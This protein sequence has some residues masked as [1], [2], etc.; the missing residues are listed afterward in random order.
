MNRGAIFGALVLF[1]AACGDHDDAEVAA[2]VA[3]VLPVRGAARIGEASHRGPARLAAGEALAVS[4]GGVAR[5]T[6][7]AGPRLLVDG[8]AELV[9]TEASRLRLAKG[10][11][12]AE[13]FPGDPLALEAGGVELFADDAALSAS[14]SGAG[15]SA[16][17]VRGEVAYRRGEA[18]GVVHAGERLELEDDA[19]SVAPE[20]L[21][22]D[23]TGG[24]ARPGPE[25][26]TASRGVGVLEGRLPDQVGEARWP[27]VVRRLDVSVRVVGDLAITEVDQVFFNPSSETVEGLYRVEV[28]AGAALHRFAVDRDG[29]LVDG[30]IRERETARRSYEA[31]VYAGSR[32][33]PALLE[34]DAPG[35]Y[36]ARIYPIDPGAE[37]RIVVR[38]SE[39]LGRAASEGPRVYRYPMGGGAR[40]A[41]VQE[42]SFR[43]DLSRTEVDHVRAGLGARVEGKVVSLRRS[44]F[45]PR[46]DLF[47]ELFDPE[48]RGAEATAYR[49]D[50][51]PPP[52]D[53]RA[54]A[55]PA[56]EE[57][58]YVYLPLRLPDDLFGE[59]GAGVDLV[60]VADVSAGTDR[61]RLEL[62]RTTVESLVTHLGPEDRVALMVSDLDVRPLATS[63]ER[64]LAEATPER[65]AALLDAL[66]REP[67][68]GATDL[69]RTLTSAAALLDPARPGAVIYIGDGAPT[70][71]ELS[72]GE[73]LARLGQLPRPLRLYAV[74]VGADADLDLMSA[75]AAG[76]GLA[77]R[78]EDRRE[79]ASAA[80]D[81]LAHARRPSAERVEVSLGT[82]VDRVY[83]RE[84][85]SVVAGAPLEIIGRAR[86][87]LPATIEVKGLVRGEPFER[88]IPLTTVAAEDEGDLRLRWAG[89]R[90]AQLIRDGAER[91]EVADLGT[92]YGVITPY[93]SF[94]VPSAAE[95][96]SM[97]DGAAP[98]LDGARFA[99]RSE[100]AREAWWLAPALPVLGLLGCSSAPEEEAPVSSS[101]APMEAARAPMADEA[102]ANGGA[103]L[104]APTVVAAP[105]AQAAMPPG[106]AEA[107]D[108]RAE[109]RPV[110]VA[111]RDEAQAAAP[112]PP[113]S[114]SPS[115]AAQA[116]NNDP[117]AGLDDFGGMGEGGGGTL[118][119]GSGSGAGSGYGRGAPAQEERGRLNRRSAPSHRAPAPTSRITITTTIQVDH[120]AKRC[121][122]ASFL[123]LEAREALWRERLERGY[124]AYE[125]LGVY[126]RALGQCELPS[127]RA[128]RAFLDLVLRRAGAV[129]PMLDFYALLARASD[130]TYLRRAI[131]RE[132]R[133]TEDLRAARAAFG[134]ERVDFELIE[135]T[136]AGANGE[137]AKLAAMRALV[138]RY[139]NDLDL[140]LRLLEMLE[141]AGRPSDAKR[142][143][144]RL[145]DHPL[146]DAGVRT[147]IGE[148]YLRMDDELE[149]RR[150]FSE[151]VEFAPSDELARRR[152][153]DLYRAHGWYE[154]AY[155]QYQTLASIRPDDPAVFLL[156]AQAAA[157]AGRIDEALR[158]EQRLAE[159]AQPGEATGPAR[160][161]ILWSSVRLAELRKDAR[162]KEDAE[163]LRAY[164]GRMRRG[165]VLREA[166]ALRASLT[167]SHPDANLSLWASHPGLSLTRPT[168]IAPEFGIEAFDL[169]EQEPGVYHVEVR[170][171]E[172]DGLTGV[173][174]KLTVVWREGRDDERVEVIPLR[175][176][177]S[178][179][180]YAWAI[181]GDALREDAPSAAAAEGGR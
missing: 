24:L 175:F 62:G 65:L 158:L 17:V 25:L 124:S 22:R 81:V 86:G 58:D 94:Y 61:S 33:D 177:A 19:L 146:A 135:H 168:D 71:G 16:Y 128:R 67:A 47:L 131:L 8:G 156:L 9:L 166:G 49:A 44:D 125:W 147:A 106:E 133:S 30:Y 76:S 20:S 12:F 46:S 149:A 104:P 41:E 72:S 174:A 155:R 97:G 89:A 163:R 114:P 73:L 45:R 140:S 38:Y 93:T 2:S 165:G 150:A 160:T 145:R 4:E 40:A 120:V 21:F 35:K 143:A 55:A 11:I 119:H 117:L 18:R 129:R 164:L 159:T 176:D 83:P 107:A 77:L 75:L 53:P 109:A 96:M 141:E 179:R 32:L 60:I 101:A 88:T 78:V 59:P 66:A 90:L 64:P 51:D 126:T 39:W 115:I 167:W 142:W 43:A 28:P 14:A 110:E 52:R 130:R 172:G 161:A 23:W 137:D 178:R 79:A 132:V 7:D 105:Q 162:A 134:A 10:R 123:V 98:L 82:R 92:R 56:E 85:A 80:L 3:S 6:L 151:I 152:L 91:E 148:M 68:G 138:E 122:D 170:R 54:G 108:T 103:L 121:G 48:G 34:W 95:L 57:S 180:A 100:R 171:R 1:A 116:P 70:V 29:H 173:T 37:R 13:A 154:D 42:L 99:I 84:A 102:A 36:R 15:V 74:G 50:H 26:A 31:Q 112:P 181:E 153:G 69:G 127:F 111:R 113:P 139:G 144:E 63:D 27:L 5:L 118:G 169:A 157:G 87:E 136:L